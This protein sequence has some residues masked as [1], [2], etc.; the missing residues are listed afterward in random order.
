MYNENIMKSSASVLLSAFIATVISF[1]AG[2]FVLNHTKAPQQFGAFNPTGS[3]TYLLQ[4]SISSTQTTIP[5]TSFTE[6]GSNIPYTMAYLN[7]SI[8]YGTIAPS[9]GNSEFIAFTGITQNSNGTA[10]LTGVTRGQA[11]SPG[12]A[13]CIASSTLAHAYSGQTQFTLTNTPCFYSQYAVKANDETITGL[14]TFSQPPV[15][16]NPGGQPNASETVSGISELATAAESGAGT[17]IGGTGA[18]LVLP[19]S[20]ATSTPTVSCS[21]F[22]VVIATAGKISESFINF[23]V[24]KTYTALNTFT[25][26]LTSTGTTT[27]SCA[28]LTTNPCVFNGVAIKWPSSNTVGVYR[29]DGL[30]NITIGNPPRITTMGA[31][32]VSLSGTGFATSTIS[33]TVASGVLTASSTVQITGTYSCASQSTTAA[34]CAISVRDGTGATFVTSPTITP[35]TSHTVTG[36]FSALILANNSLSSQ[37]TFLSGTLIDSTLISNLQQLDTIGTSAVNTANATTFTVVVHGTNSTDLNTLT[38]IAYVVNP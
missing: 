3:G 9:S 37:K 15:G 26:G 25:G 8:E 28:S 31:A 18:R 36:T 17:S 14:Y 32:G 34:A 13:G 4:S 5:L 30:G 11:R 33:V 20:L 24:T 35:S 22:C 2:A 6:P 29:N 27:V 12:N 10:T 1:G 38:N 19:A 23:A 7:S 16:I 21:A